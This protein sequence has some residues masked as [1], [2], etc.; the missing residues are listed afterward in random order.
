MK[1]KIF[2]YSLFLGIAPMASAQSYFKTKWNQKLLL[3]T[4]YNYSWSTVSGDNQPETYARKPSS[5][6]HIRSEYYLTRFIG[7]GLA[8]GFQQKGA[9]IKYPDVI[10]EIGNPDSTNRMR[11]RFNTMNF[12]VYIVLRTPKDVIKG[13]RLSGHLGF[14]Y[15]KNFLTRTVWNS[16]EDGF[17]TVTDRSADYFKSDIGL[18]GAFGIDIN[19]GN[20]DAIFQVQCVAS[21]GKKNVYR[22][23][24]VFGNVDGKSNIIGLQLSF[25]Y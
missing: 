19:S 6:A 24:A 13:V 1:S 9:I 11:L 17:H 20:G 3:G 10:K 14:N 16:V 21:W 22:N 25:M 8:A 23:Q 15:D 7:V 2:L 18:Y 12:P 5:G 4:S